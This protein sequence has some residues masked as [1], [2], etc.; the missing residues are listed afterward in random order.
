M[1][2]I[3]IR[4]V[5]PLGDVDVPILRREGENYLSAG[6]VVEVDAELGEA[7]LEQTGNYVLVVD[8]EDDL[9]TF[10][11]PEL[12]DYASRN[13]IDL[14]G[15]RRKADILAAIAAGSDSEDDDGADDGAD[16]ADTD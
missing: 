4:N 16:G 2:T 5:N 1:S 6:E 10:T 14:G 3:K 8:V 12:R 13:G 11:V 9:D 7:L 15:A